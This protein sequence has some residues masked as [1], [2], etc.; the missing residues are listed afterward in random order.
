MAAALTLVVSA[1][2]GWSRGQPPEITDAGAIAAWAVPI[3]AACAPLAVRRRLPLTAVAA[4]A[5]VVLVVSLALER[6]A[7]IWVLGLAVASA[8]Y[9]R[10]RLRLALLAGSIAWAAALGVQSGAAP[11]LAAMSVYAVAGAAPVAVGYALRLRADRAAQAQRLQRARE[12]RARAQEAARIARDVHDIVGHHLSAIR[13]QAVGARRALGGRDPEADR[14]LGGI[15]GLSAEALAEIRA[16]LATLVRSDTENE[17]HRPGIA[18]LA[19]LAERSGGSEL[20]VALDVDPHLD[21][22]LSAETELCVYRIVQEALTNAARHSAAG[23]ASV[24]VRPAGGR[25]TVT[26][27]DPGPP[28]ISP[29]QDTGDGS[30]LEGGRGLAGMRERVAALGGR[31]HA[32]PNGQV[33]WRVRADLPPHPPQ[34]G[35]PAAKS[36]GGEAGPQTAPVDDR[37]AARVTR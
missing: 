15:A 17:A 18:D 19:T 24:K 8:A 21:G 2:E 5:A 11:G 29:G 30:V 34:E 32:G 6:D 37:P 13:L 33:G 35:G 28:R 31:C 9:H 25:I 14:A 20:V 7:G 3:V 36:R 26:V 22:A 12:E 1:L 27:D 4:S 23:S 10:H 16:L